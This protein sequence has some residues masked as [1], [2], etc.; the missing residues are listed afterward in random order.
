MILCL[1]YDEGVLNFGTYWE[2]NPTL[3]EFS[4]ISTKSILFYFVLL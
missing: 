2:K 4:S 1:V 3:W